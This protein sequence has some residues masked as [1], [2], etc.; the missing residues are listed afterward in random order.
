MQR[1][2]SI[3][4]LIVTLFAINGAAQQYVPKENEEIYGR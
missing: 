3:S 1:M 2:V 4:L